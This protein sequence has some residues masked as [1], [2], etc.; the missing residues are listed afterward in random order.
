[1][2]YHRQLAPARFQLVLAQNISAQIGS[3]ALPQV[4]IAPSDDLL[5]WHRSRPVLR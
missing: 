5:L 2:G 4:V 3:A 1:M